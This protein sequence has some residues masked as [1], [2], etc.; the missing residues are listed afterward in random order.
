MSKEVYI[1]PEMDIVCF[2]T[3]DIITTSGIS[4]D[5]GGIDTP[6]DFF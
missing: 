2:E 1:S 4:V 3:E 6:Y 5:E